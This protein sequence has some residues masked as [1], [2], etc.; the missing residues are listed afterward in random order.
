MRMNRPLAV[1]VLGLWVFS[2]FLMTATH[3]T[4]GPAVAA[5]GAEAVAVVAHHHGIADVIQPAGHGETGHHPA[6]H[7]STPFDSTA[8]CD[9]GCLM[10]AA[11]REGALVHPPLD[12]RH[13]PAVG[14]TPA[15]QPY[16]LTS[17]PPETFA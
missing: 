6:K 12:S 2:Q 17:P 16:F 3:L 11:G 9:V 1:L 4:S 13:V 15:E 14:R 5:S 7:D 10:I 8:H